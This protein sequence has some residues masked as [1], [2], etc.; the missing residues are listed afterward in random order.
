M[1]SAGGSILGPRRRSKDHGD[2]IFEGKRTK[3]AWKVLLRTT[4]CVLTGLCWAFCAFRP[5][6]DF[7]TGGGW[8]PKQDCLSDLKKCAEKFAQ[9][10][11]TPSYASNIL[12]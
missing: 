10:V 9:T 11:K 1:R 12:N 2:Q 5:P 8:S 6:N 4:L 3:S 7:T